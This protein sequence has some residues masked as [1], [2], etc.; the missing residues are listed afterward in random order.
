MRHRALDWFLLAVVLIGGVLAAQTSRERA[1]L[2]QHY[3]RLI[4][5]TGELPITEPSKV[6]V[7][8]LDT[9]EPLHF[10]WRIYLPAKSKQRW[11][12]H[13][14]GSSSTSTTSS[15]TPSEFVGR[16]RFRQDEQGRL[17]LYERLSNTSSRMTFGD[18]ALAELLRDR[19]DKV[20]V[21]QLGSPRLAVLDPDQPAVFLRLTLPEDL[22][23]EA[24]KK[25]PPFTVTQ[26]VPILFEW[27]FGPDVANP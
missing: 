18:Q 24:R 8:A 26:Y 20:R 1:R 17:E 12:S 4:Q 10:A 7:R 6:Y 11:S 25:L 9:G 23:E 21:E 13:W 14:A 15:N 3:R 22:Q 16:L 27:D 19:W 5:M 2:E